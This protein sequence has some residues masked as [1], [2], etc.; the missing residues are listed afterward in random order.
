MFFCLFWKNFQLLFLS[1]L[2]LGSLKWCFSLLKM[3]FLAV[4]YKMVLEFCFIVF[5]SQREGKIL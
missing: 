3:E 2:S 1:F 5:V 4:A